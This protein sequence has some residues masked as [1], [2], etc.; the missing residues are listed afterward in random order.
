MKTKK[1]DMFFPLTIFF[2]AFLLF[3][4]QPLFAK[5]ILPWFGGS[6]AVWTTC[7]LFFQAFLLAGYTYAHITTRYFSGRTQAI[8]HIA[9][10]LTALAFLPIVPDPRCIPAPGQNPT[11]PILLLLTRY[12]G[13]PYLMLAAA[14]PL[15]QK[16]SSLLDPEE[17]P[18]RLYALSNAGALL[19]LISFP[20]VLEPS[21]SR[22]AQANVWQWSFGV[23]V[24]L[25]GANA[26]RFW[27]SYPTEAVSPSQTTK[28]P[29]PAGTA[30]TPSNLD[31]FLWFVL[32]ACASVLLLAVTNKL[33]QDVASIPFLWMLPLCFYLLTFI[34]CF[35][36]P[37]WYKR[38]LFTLL[39]VPLLGLL[40]VVLFQELDVSW[41]WQAA[42][43]LGVLFVGGMVCHGEL[44]RLKPPPRYLTS[45]YL[46][47]AAGGAAGGVLVAVVA[48]LVFRSFAELSWGVWLLGMLVVFLHA[49]EKTGWKAGGHRLAAWPFLLGGT[50]VLGTML[51]LQN[52]RENL[53][54]AYMS[55]NFYGVLRIIEQNKDTPFHS[56]TLK[57]GSI[58]HGLQFVDPDKAA[59]PTT[60]YNEQSGVGLAI[61]YLAHMANRNIGVVGLGTGTLAAYGRPGDTLRFYEINPEVLR[62][63]ETRF[64]FLKGS[65][66]RVQ[67]VLGDARLSLER[68]PPQKFDLLV[69]DAFS[70]DAIP[71][72]LLTREAFSTYLRHLK[73]DG[74]IAVH[75]S[76]RYLNLF[77]VI[78]GAA[79]N[80]HLTMT[81]IFR[82]APMSLCDQPSKWILLS[83]NAEFLKSEPIRQAAS[84]VPPHSTAPLIWTDDYASLLSIVKW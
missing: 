82:E 68:E 17:S 20:L 14:S 31:R 15:I 5:F 49:R 3:Q 7:L 32:A 50:I 74:I 66:A 80:F 67:V 51:F 22:Q 18:Y 36:R 16:W 64:T 37:T 76:N 62:L 48:P 52:C 23:F 43:Y 57:H 28:M 46:F 81:S 63:A 71:V 55:R 21:L 8:L 25:C 1:T 41:P 6:Q 29:Q 4:V 72:H 40:V 54:A 60:Y 73:T 53:E 70:S 77:P 59:I 2:G 13:L 33:C 83:R 27:R 84:L 19:A 61:H 79:L 45:F 26:W 78:L 30:P 69:L 47:L 11:G 75:I 58:I 35:N 56:L 12:L 24:L 10:L 34:F 39:L 9:L 38:G 44:N 65:K 42:V